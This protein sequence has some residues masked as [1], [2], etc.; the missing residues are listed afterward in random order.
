[1]SS[2][3]KNQTGIGAD[4]NSGSG[5]ELRRLPVNYEQA[6]IGAPDDNILTVEDGSFSIK[7]REEPSLHGINV[8]FRRSSFTMIVG[9]VGSG[10]SILLKSLVGEIP[11]CKGF[12]GP[13]SG[14]D[15]YCDRTPWLVND[16]M[17][18]NILGVSSFDQQW[19]ETVLQACALQEDISELLNG[20]ESLV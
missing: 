17:P 8:S 7:D 16:T 15:A 9:P 1:L 20:D 12:V 14:S 2:S 11:S 4:S 19:H 10:K 3:P 5:I 18:K 13:K 6:Q